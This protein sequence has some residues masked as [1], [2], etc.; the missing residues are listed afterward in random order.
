MKKS[1]LLS[2]LLA[3][4]CPR[5]PAALPP[6]EELLPDDTLAVLTVRDWDRACAVYDASPQGQLWRDPDMK[7]V[8]DKFLNKFHTTVLAP[9]ETALG[10]KFADYTNLVHGQVTLAVTPGDWRGDPGQTPGWLLLADAKDKGDALKNA[11][12]DLRKKWVAAGKPTRTTRIRELDFTTVVI[13][14]A[15][16]S[17]TMRQAFGGSKPADAGADNSAGK[18]SG[19][20]LEI[21]VGQ[22]GSLLIVGSAPKDIEKVLALQTGGLVPK[23]VSQPAFV[24][25]QG[26]FRDALAFAW[27]NFAPIAQILDKKAAEANPPSQP[28]NPMAL[29]PRKVLAATGLDALKTLA[30]SLSDSRD[31]N[32]AR[33]FI[34]VPEASRKGLFKIIALE[35]K[36][37]APPAFVPADIVKFNR[38]RLDAQKAWSTIEAMVN[39]ISPELSGLL[40]MT[41][42]AAGKDKDPN[43]DL[44]KSLIGNL[45]DDFISYQRKPRALTLEAL[46]SPPSVILLGSPNA[47]QLAQALKI[48]VTL[49]AP[50]GAKE[51]DFLGRKIYTLPLPQQRGPTGAPAPARSL[52]FAASGGYLALSTDDAMLE[53]YL[54]SG[55]TKAKALGETAGLNE[56]AQKVGG[57]Q[58][59][60]FGYENQ[61]ESMRVTVEALKQNADL[62]DQVL[63]L[64]L[65]GGDV[66]GLSAG[67]SLKDWIDFSLLPPY[68][69]IAKYFYFVVYAASAGPDGLSLKIFSPLPP[70]LKN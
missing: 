5:T 24:G 68:E 18:K 49:L 28:D 39:E 6:A 1:L 32:L 29:Q 69:R 23:L 61:S 35:P 51:R 26:L 65:G 59:G 44:K 34:G 42:N 19:T 41:L 57:M 53:E 70:Q 10:V 13:D 50:A 48:G 14:S 20:Q 54:R 55:E 16:V 30:L 17:Q 46:N 7:A 60:L 15:D 45:G 8:K 66:N 62:M 4:T 56:A 37:A 12:A 47:E 40:Q 22:S 11:L 52:S 2:A 38:W 27:V 67:K 36:D 9:L 33:L 63:A 58:S 25:D 43:Y 64:R 31:G 3:L 21:T